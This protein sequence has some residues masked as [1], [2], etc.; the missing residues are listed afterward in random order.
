[1]PTTD[2]APEDLTITIE[3]VFAAPRPLV[4]R[5]W[6]TKEDM[7]R[8][9]APKG[10]VITHS[11]GDF[12]I[13]GKWRCCMRAPHG[14]PFNVGGTYQEIVPNERIVFTHLWE[15]DDGPGHETVVTVNLS[16][17][18]GGTRMSFHQGPFKSVE[19]REGH[20]GGWTECFDLL[21]E[22]L[23]KVQR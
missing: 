11:E 12:R 6:R 8:W 19:S 7:D 15:E 16:D 20:R 1:M 23:A 13:G 2:P 3:R 4:F 17:E 22:H 9:S 14:E 21:A 5:A 10:F 18:G